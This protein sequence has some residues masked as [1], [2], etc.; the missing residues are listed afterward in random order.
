MRSIL[1]C[2]RR[3]ALGERLGMRNGEENRY[4]ATQQKLWFTDGEVALLLF[5][6][7]KILWQHLVPGGKPGFGHQHSFIL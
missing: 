2:A 5:Q 4:V 7:Y 1:S 3:S 6:D